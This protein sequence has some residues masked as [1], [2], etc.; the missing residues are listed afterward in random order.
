MHISRFR[1]DPEYTISGCF[2]QERIVCRFP[3]LPLFQK[4]ADCRESGIIDLFFTRKVQ[5]PESVERVRRAFQFFFSCRLRFVTEQISDRIPEKR[6]VQSA[7]GGFIRTKHL[8]LTGFHLFPVQSADILNLEQRSIRIEH[9]GKSD[10]LKAVT[11]FGDLI[12][13]F[14]FYTVI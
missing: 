9:H 3:G 1:L 2:R 6:G 14:I 11:G 5:F 10:F 7:S 13:R 8:K 12:S 4:T